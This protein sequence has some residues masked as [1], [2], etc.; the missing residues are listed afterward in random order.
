MRIA[1]MLR[2]LML[3]AIWG[4][5][6]LFM[7]MAAPE[8]GVVWTAEIRVGV[9]ALALLIYLA[10]TKQALAW[11]EHQREYWVI[12]VLGSALPFSLYAFAALHLPAG[13]SAIVNST[14]PL[15]S[16]L[17]GVLFWGE[18]LS[19]RAVFGLLCGVVGVGFLVQLGPLVL[20]W[21]SLLGVAACSGAALCYALAG[22]Y[23]KRRALTVAVPLMATGSQLAA[24]LVILPVS[25][26]TPPPMQASLSAWGA[27]L[28]LALLCSALAYLLYFR[29][30]VEIGPSKAL[31]VTF[32]IPLFA[33]LWGW[34]FLQEAVTSSMLFGCVLVVLAMGLVGYQKKPTQEEA[35]LKASL[36]QDQ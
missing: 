19:W 6:F 36:K 16:A 33:M 35:S 7:R 14:S 26:F 27:V 8:M 10:C 5:S 3:A 29:I 23:S 20:T 25:L 9:A 24:A 4:A 32:L 17:L 1:V 34:L 13:Y 30:V 12:G 21:D 31:T 28:A 18:R 22:I 15:W 2:L 11:R